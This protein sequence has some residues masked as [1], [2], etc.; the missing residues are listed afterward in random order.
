MVT[1]KE[2]IVKDTLVSGPTEGGGV[3]PRLL[4]EPLTELTGLGMIHFRKRTSHESRS[5]SPIRWT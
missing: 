5:H 1:P 2:S 4:M 3:E